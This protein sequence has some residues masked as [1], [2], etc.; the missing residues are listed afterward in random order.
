MFFILFSM[1]KKKVTRSNLPDEFEWTIIQKYGAIW[2]L[3]LLLGGFFLAIK[4]EI[5]GIIG[6][7]Q[8]VGGLFLIQGLITARLLKLIITY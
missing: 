5:G 8:I 4:G 7:P 3:V 2:T 1:V 6:T